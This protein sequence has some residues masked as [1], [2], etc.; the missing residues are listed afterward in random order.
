[1]TADPHET[2]L[3]ME[4]LQ[5][6]WLEGQSLAL[7]RMAQRSQLQE[8]GFAPLN[9]AG[10]HPQSTHADTILTARHTHAFCLG[11]L[12]GI[13]G[14][15]PMARHGIEALSTILRD[16]RYGGWYLSARPAGGETREKYAYCHAFV[17]LAACSAVSCGIK[18]ADTL[19][20]DAVSVINTHFWDDDAGAMRESFSFNWEKEEAYRGA[21][22]NM[23]SVEAFLALADTLNDPLW[24]QRALRICTRIIHDVAARHDYQ[25]V[26]HFDRS[27]SVL[28][29]YHLDNPADPL[30]P[31]GTTPGHGLEWSH[32]LLKLEASLRAFGLDAPDW[33]LPA[34]G[35]LFDAAMTYGW[36]EGPHPGLAY[37]LDWRKHP[38]VI[39]HVHW[40]IA[41]AINA[42]VSLA[43]R[44]GDQRYQDWQARLWDYAAT[45]L[46][47][48]EG[49]GWWNELDALNRPQD[50]II[51]PGKSDLYHAFQ[52]TLAPT[53]PLAS[54]F[55]VAI[56][57]DQKQRQPASV[58]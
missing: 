32:L 9:T 14:C 3:R 13:P 38:S 40:A 21:N 57:A 19:L 55:V 8:G 10:T 16:T 11:T 12:L 44:T 5:R 43:L 7:L 17:A 45:Y 26:E 20:A 27:W 42:A 33:L 29:D 47:D 4:P 30:R 58:G 1:M 34:S 36:V 25:V 6:R 23:H 41:E 31:Y 39:H 24:T 15:R 35:H 53:L 48:P 37:T 52:A 54:S 28:Y 51:T 50:M 22:A 49:E 56:Q 18:G 2:A 46:V